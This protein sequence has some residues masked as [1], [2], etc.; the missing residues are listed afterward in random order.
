M[1]SRSLR[2]HDGHIRIRNYH[3]ESSLLG[4]RVCQATRGK[5]QEN[6]LGTKGVWNRK[7]KSPRRQDKRNEVEARLYAFEK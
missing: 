4:I 7:V 1:N 2:C 3:G 5:C 6:R